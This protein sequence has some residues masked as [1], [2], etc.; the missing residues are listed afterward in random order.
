MT[1][2][3][4]AALFGAPQPSQ[5]PP[6][7]MTT[8]NALD[9]SRHANPGFS[10]NPNPLGLKPRPGSS[11]CLCMGCGRPFNSVS[12]FDKHQ[13]LTKGA[14]TCRDPASLGMVTNA[15]GWWVLSLREMDE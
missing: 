7:E 11:Q 6:I 13:T 1:T 5:V 9:S 15:R 2:A 4:Q 12:A 3:T 10:D 14:V 8:K